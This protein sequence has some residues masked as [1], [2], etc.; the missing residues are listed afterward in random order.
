M[1]G[2]YEA[3]IG[4]HQR[5]LAIKPD[6]T[7]ERYNLGIACKEVLRLPEAAECY[8][9]VLEKEPDNVGA[10]HG[11][12][13]VMMMQGYAS[14]A[15]KVF[16]KALTIKPDDPAS[17]SCLLLAMNY[18][19][20]DPQQL[21]QA[22]VEWDRFNP[23]KA[24]E[25]LAGPGQE[26]RPLRVGYV[27]PDF[28]NHPVAYFLAPLLAH[29]NK[30]EFEVY[31]YS[32][33]GRPDGITAY[34]REQASVWRDTQPLSD[35]ALATRIANDHIDILVDLAGHTANN[36]LRVFARKPAP[37][38]VTYLGYPNTTGL[39]AMDYRL[40]DAWADPPGMTEHLHSESLLRL[41]SGFLCYRPLDGSVVASPPSTEKRYITF[42]SFNNLAKV[43]PDVISLWARV[44]LAVPG[45]RLLLKTKP[46]HDKITRQNVYR[47]FDACGV[48]RERIELVGWVDSLGGHL[49]LYSKVDIGLDTFPYNGTTT[50][51]EALWMGVPVV[52][53]EGVSHAGRVG[54]SILSQTGLTEFIASDRES[55][56][57]IAASL[58]ADPER[59]VALRKA[60]RAQVA[61]SA[62]CN[63]PALAGEVEKHYR[64]IWAKYSS[65]VQHETG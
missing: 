30:A 27:S 23:Y 48:E 14:E 1:L 54:V 9:Q 18:F 41:E 38:Q 4:Y 39:A 56:I 40:T 19:S 47:Q 32:D 45:S 16:H 13:I 34:F 51:C 58:A 60:S 2:Q 8:K 44:L 63:A 12:G 62:L 31:C 7:G 35:E 42:G 11:L 5:A 36:R 33:V 55:Y 61:E 3:A 26:G 17:R 52:T 46:L 21:F 10:L 59:L 37:L 64:D 29:H 22:H 65:S 53:L 50:T 24:R 43:T 28:C 49:G 20:G 25:N 57:E 6:L 15:E